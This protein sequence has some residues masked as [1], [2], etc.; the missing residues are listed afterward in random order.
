M[1]RSAATAIAG[2]VLRPTGSSRMAAGFAPTVDVRLEQSR[3][4]VLVMVSKYDHCLVD[5]LYRWIDPRVR[6]GAA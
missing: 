5:L 6:G 2:A 4:R 1:A 3:R